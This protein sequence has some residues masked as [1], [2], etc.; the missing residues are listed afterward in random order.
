MAKKI[1]LSPTIYQNKHTNK[2][3]RVPSL[4]EPVVRLENMAQ[5]RLKKSD[6]AVLRALVREHVLSTAVPDFVLIQA[7]DQT[8]DALR[9][10]LLRYIQVYKS[11]DPI[12]RANAEKAMEKMLTGLQDDVKTAFEER[13]LDFTQ[14]F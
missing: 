1:G 14:S 9:R 11:K 7:L 5:D 10:E 6:E 13:M 12:E 4:K 2:Q 3:M 8:T